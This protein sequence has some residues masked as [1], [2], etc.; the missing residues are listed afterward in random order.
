VTARSQ[1]TPKFLPGDR[2]PVFL[3]TDTI[4]DAWSW[5][6]L[7]EA[8][9]YGVTRFNA[10]HARLG[11]SRET[12]SGRL[13]DL[14]GG[15]LL[16]LEGSDYRLTPCGRDLFGCLVAAMQWGERWC[17]DEGPTPLRLTHRRG[18]HAFI[19][20]FRCVCCREPV[21][22]RDVAID[23]AARTS[24]E[25]I[26]AHRHRAPNLD[27]LE[28]ESP[29]AI[30]RTLHVCGDRW[31]S[32]VIRECFMG[33]R[34]FDD[35]SRHLGIAPNILTQRL[36]RLVHLGMLARRPYQQRPARHEYRLTEKGL[37]YYCV[38]LA[39][40]TWAQ[41][42]LPRG[43]RGIVLRHQTCGRQLTAI[44]TCRRCAAPVGRGD[45]EIKSRTIRHG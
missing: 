26:G 12:L 19:P 29:C 43:R 28:R 38:P 21:Q 35:F 14:R 31:T 24:A 30:A 5:L 8:V 20:V 3:A 39:M 2:D 7:R 36:D 13:D 23:A 17:A 32:L 37:D 45:V 18:G 33:T 42:W 27:I 22:A 11:I 9:F 1:P 34:R 41:R 40:L 15:G 44:L 16:V 4:G 25:L 6:I 10:F